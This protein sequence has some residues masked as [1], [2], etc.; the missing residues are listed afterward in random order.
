V[1]VAPLDDG[2]DCREMLA[3]EG[4]GL[5]AAAVCGPALAGTSPTVVTTFVTALLA[6]RLVVATLPAC[7]AITGESTAADPVAAER[8]IMVGVAT[9]SVADEAT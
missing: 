6:L 3:D 4:P 1:R 7:E 8:R 9:G 2:A 5:A